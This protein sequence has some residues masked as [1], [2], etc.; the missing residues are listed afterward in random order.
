ML[1]GKLTPTID[2]QT[3]ADP[4]ADYRT[5]QKIGSFRV[6]EAALYQPNGTYLLR[7][8]IAGAESGMGK[9]HVTGCCAGGVP[10]PRVLITTIDGKKLQ[11]LCDSKAISQRLADALNGNEA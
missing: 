9:T 4:K 6:S 2:G 5:A 11:L 7:S 10:V 1:F 8:S 3:L